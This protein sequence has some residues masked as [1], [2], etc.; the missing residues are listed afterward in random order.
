ME[1]R[2]ETAN[3]ILYSRRLGKAVVARTRVA[4][5]RHGCTITS[6]G[7]QR[8]TDHLTNPV[9]KRTS[10]PIAQIPPSAVAP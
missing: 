3:T 1:P 6:C 8:W 2:W 5:N 10:T 9:T 7:S 4:A